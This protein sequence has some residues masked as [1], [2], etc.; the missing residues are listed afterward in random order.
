MRVIHN[1]K[2]APT[3]IEAYRQLVFN[4][5]VRGVLMLIDALPAMQLELSPENEVGDFTRT[6][7]A[8]QMTD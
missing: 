8:G 7:L 5:I 3:E 2:F 1:D 4:N 6:L